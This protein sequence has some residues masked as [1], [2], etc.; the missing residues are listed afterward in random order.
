MSRKITRFV[1]RPQRLYLLAAA[2]ALHLCLSA[3]L[4]LVGRLNLLP[5][6]V[7]RDG[8]IKAFADNYLYQKEAALL[9]GKLTQEGF[10]AWL[11]APALPHVKLYSIL[12][13]LF[14]P[15]LGHS[16]LSVEPL[17]LLYYLSILILVYKLGENIFDGQTGMI[18]AGAVALW[19]SFLVHTLQLLKDSLFIAA[20]LALLL[21]ASGWLTKAYGRREGLV[22]GFAGGVL[23]VLLALVRPEFKV[24]VLAVVSLALMLLFVRQMR[25]RRLL[26]GNLLS[27][28]V[29]VL[30]L[31]PSTY[32]GVTRFRGIKRA[33]PA[34][35]TVT[36]DA[37]M[38]QP[39]EV[40]NK[41]AAVESKATGAGLAGEGQMGGE[42]QVGWLAF[43]RS[44][45][46]SAASR[47]GAIRHN[48][49]VGYPD[50]NSTIDGDVAF[51][52][53]A[54]VL[55][56][57][58]RAC[59][60]GFLSP[61]PDTWFASSPRVGLTGKSIS[62]VE[63]LVMYAV[64][65]LAIFGLFQSRRSTAAWLLFLVAAIGVTT[66]GLVVA[67]AG[68]LYR[69]RYLFW[70]LFIILGARGAVHVSASLRRG[71]RAASED[72]GGA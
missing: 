51:D 29:V 38:S 71:R 32:L 66:L 7:D 34:S 23:I 31:L 52:D 37:E 26:P 1:N 60:V 28:A 65:I 25:D 5:E 36:T 22:T 59:V 67:N 15:A 48:F 44:G 3:G 18:A 6:I 69:Q 8:L 13:A 10:W 61:F 33:P 41:T 49:V 21:V 68:A 45:A 55:R 62:A 58:P 12:F 4:H 50:S 39:A 57:L 47:L 35:S 27:A 11:T 54:D 19:P 72:L 42:G 46:D 56:Y 30:L 63:T 2:A 64:Q 53:A 40:E 43:L 24:M 70:F 17:N 16:V 20:A 9:S 14:G